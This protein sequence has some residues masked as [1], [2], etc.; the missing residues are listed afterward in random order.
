MKGDDVAGFKSDRAAPNLMSAAMGCHRGA[1]QQRQ[2]NEQPGA[3]AVGGSGG[4]GAFDGSGVTTSNASAPVITAAR[5][6]TSAVNEA[7]DLRARVEK[8]EAQRSND[9][10][11]E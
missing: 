7:P 8:L 1:A 6:V 3:F 2:V 5:A 11:E 4:E 9:V 10:S